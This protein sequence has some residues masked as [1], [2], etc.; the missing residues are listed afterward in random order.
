MTLLHQH[1]VMF[2]HHR[3]QQTI[4]YGRKYNASHTLP[5]SKWI[6]QLGIE[7]LLNQRC[8]ELSGGQAQRVALLRALNTGRPWLLLDE[9]FTALDAP[10][11]LAACDVIAEYCQL[12]GAGLLVASHQDL[13]QRYLCSS[14]YVVESLSGQYVEDLFPVL[15]KQESLQL[16][17]T[18]TVN[19]EAIEHG[20]LLTRLA[21][22]A[23]YLN[24]PNHWQP[25][26]ARVSIDA[27]DIALAIGEEHLTSMVNRLKTQVR[28]I[29]HIN[30]ERVRLWLVIGDQ[31]LV[32]DISPWSFNRLNIQLG[33]S[34][35]AE[36]KVGAVQWHGQAFA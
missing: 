6:Q 31:Q 26:S 12:T 17:S 5:L 16:T 29:D 35:F 21:G 19:V 32:V 13:P 27:G 11:V 23:L 15:N 8:H 2:G 34:L 20:F 3:V 30:S 18:L 24:L 22:Q 14:A 28:A 10:R 7:P 33:Q 1:P 9:A 36:F 25:A 4:D